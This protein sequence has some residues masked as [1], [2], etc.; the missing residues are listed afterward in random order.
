MFKR[1]MKVVQALYAKFSGKYAMPGQTKYVSMDEFVEMVT[2]SGVVDDTFGSREIQP[3]FN[4]SMM[5]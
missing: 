1:F 4:L 5:T 3:L 2:M